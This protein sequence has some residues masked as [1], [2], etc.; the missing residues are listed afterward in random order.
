MRIRGVVFD[1]DG[2][3]IDSEVLYEETSLQ[4]MAEMGFEPSREVI[5]RSIGLPEPGWM[6]IVAEHFGPTFDSGHYRDRCAEMMAEWYERKTMPLKP[7]VFELLDYLRDRGIPCAIASS[8]A[9]VRALGV[10][11]RLGILPYIQGYTFGDMV[12][13]GKPAPDIF[14]AA[15]ATLGLAPAD[16]MGVEDS[17]NGV[18][19]CK[20]A[21]L[22]TVM[23]PDLLPETEEIRPLLDICLPTLV[24]IIPLVERLN[25][26][27][28]KGQ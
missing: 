21:G 22:Y 6:G 23:V 18:R 2:T 8:T 19:S 15:A 10:L 12:Q 1:M 24:D 13:N 20:A 11:E 5:H 9:K 7:G 26:E 14:I 3:L 4:I 16:C 28:Q 25:S 17:Y 27:C